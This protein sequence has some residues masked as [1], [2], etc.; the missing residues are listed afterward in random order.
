MESL[1]N[2]DKNSKDVADLGSQYTFDLL[3]KFQLSDS[4]LFEIFDYCKKKGSIPLCTPW[5]LISLEKL[6]EYGLDAFKIASADLTN[7]FLLTEAAS[8]SKP[9][10]C[11]TGMSTEKEIISSI[12][13]L[14]KLN[15]RFILLHC[16]STYPAPLKDINLNYILRL[17]G[18]TN[19][20]VG[21]S[22]HE[23]GINVAI[24]S[25]ALGA[26]VIE[27]HFTFD[28]NLEGN[29]HKVSLL[30]KEFSQMVSGIRE[31]E[32]ASS[33][34]SE[35]TLSQGEMINRDVLAKSLIAKSSISKG[36]V[37][38]RDII[39]IKTPG[40][41]L[42]PYYIDELVGRRSSRDIKEGDFFYES[43]IGENKIEPRDYKFSRPYGIPV[44][45]HDFSSLH[46]VSKFDFLEFHLSYGDLEVDI[47]SYLD[48]KHSLG[49][50][51][52]SPELFKEDH[53]LDM[54][55]SNKEYLS[56]SVK[57]LEDVCSMTSKL[58]KYFQC[59]NDPM[60]VVNAGGFSEDNFIEKKLA[61]N[62]Y[63]KMASSLSQ[64]NALDTEIIIQTMPPFPWHFG[65]QRYHNL[66]VDPL[67]I[68][69]FCKKNN[70]RICLDISHAQM[71]CSYYGWTLE[72]YVKEVSDY[73]AHLHISDSIGHDGEGVRFGKGDVN[74]LS[75][76]KLLKRNIPNIG[77]I[78]EVWQGHV[79]EGQ[80]F[81]EALEYLEDIQF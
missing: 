48:N 12:H 46:E 3:S 52:H 18:L 27:K 74:F 51:V 26:K 66:F 67:E 11:S 62:L 50:I 30:P 10:I 5:D 24:S 75:L 60:I 61:L 45:F 9:L 8:L 40:N 47:E 59:P 80:G 21:Y 35:R 2:F 6:D 25:V 32:E 19:S 58:R 81:W 29:D 20:F 14:E 23:R 68:S 22:G 44:R 34:V 33:S 54:V 57:N 39:S 65:G 49:L 36:Q 42:Q 38:T 4:E 1:Y 31:I 16:N 7:H 56:R 28:K 63:E 79:N 72:D 77:F 15:S 73:V 17:K 71:A 43:D 69:N 37:I 13:L 55:S 41:G 78:P 64:V 70:Y 76:S 53:I